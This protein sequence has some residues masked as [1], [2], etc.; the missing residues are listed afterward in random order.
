MFK[1]VTLV[2]GLSSY[3]KLFLKDLAFFLNPGFE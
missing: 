2:H 3:N 1:L